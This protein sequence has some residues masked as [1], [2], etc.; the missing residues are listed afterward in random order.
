[1][2]QLPLK[3]NRTNQSHNPIEGILIEGVDYAGKTAVTKCLTEMLITCYGKNAMYKKDYLTENHLVKYL[4]SMAQTMKVGES[5]NLPLVFAKL[6]DIYVYTPKK[7]DFIVQD[8]HWFSTE[9]RINFFY[10]K[11]TLAKLL[12]LYRFHIPFAYNIYLTSSITTKEKRVMRSPPKSSIDKY[13]AKNPDVHQKYDDFCKHLIPQNENWH[14]II[15]DN[16]SIDQICETII[17]LT[18]SKLLLSPQRF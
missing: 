16:Q 5:Q 8:R 2:R 6:V 12:L 11:S 4:A 18:K 9:C 13:L 17:S 1:M 10:P 7:G 15:T 3:I 14:V